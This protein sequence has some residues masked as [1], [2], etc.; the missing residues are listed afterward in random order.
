M[1]RTK[2]LIILYILPTIAVL[3]ALLIHAGYVTTMLLFWGIPALILTIWAPKHI[4]K[5]ALFSLVGTIFFTA[6]DIIFYKTGQ[7]YVT[8]SHHRIFGLVASG[9]I[10]FWFLFIY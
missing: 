7:W 3:L 1:T 8:Q 10:L 6:I 4:Y 9:D 5:A 2:K